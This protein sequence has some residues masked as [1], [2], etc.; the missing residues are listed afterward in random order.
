MLLLRLFLVAAA[1]CCLLV[2]RSGTSPQTLPKAARRPLLYYPCYGHPPHRYTCFASPELLCSHAQAL[3]ASRS[4]TARDRPISRTSSPAGTYVAP[5]VEL[6]CPLFG[7]MLSLRFGQ[8][9]S[10]GVFFPVKHRNAPL[11]QNQLTAAHYEC[12]CPNQPQLWML[13]LQVTA[14]SALLQ[15]TPF[16]AQLPK[17]QEPL[18]AVLTFSHRFQSP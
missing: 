7:Q 16:G 6:V 9:A 11:A 5:T 3:Q 8:L 17:L 14:A 15:P 1:C 12:A 13:L 10:G 2:A 18:A 4:P